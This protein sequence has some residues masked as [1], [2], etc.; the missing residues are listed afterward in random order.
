MKIV[1]VITTP[2]VIDKILGHLR[3]TGKDDPFAARAPPAA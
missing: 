3:K 1:S 2:A